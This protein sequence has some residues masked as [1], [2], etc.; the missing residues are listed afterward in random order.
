M[1]ST[2]APPAIHWHTGRMR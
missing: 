2:R 1:E